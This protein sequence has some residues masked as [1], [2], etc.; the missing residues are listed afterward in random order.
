MYSLVCR[1]TRQLQKPYKRFSADLATQLFEIL[2]NCS[3]DA[4]KLNIG[5][6]KLYKQDEGWHAECNSAA[7]SVLM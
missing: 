1:L 3:L 7:E 6:N 2:K 5:I 4:L